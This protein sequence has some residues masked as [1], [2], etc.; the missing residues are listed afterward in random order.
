MDVAI[1]S[2]AS[3]HFTF[4]E[5]KIFPPD[6][7]LAMF[8]S[9]E[10]VTPKHSRVEVAILWIWGFIKFEGKELSIG[11]STIGGSSE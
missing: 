8:L 9:G 2:D 5:G 4:L 11:R 6:F 1:H 10:D 3:F 7:D